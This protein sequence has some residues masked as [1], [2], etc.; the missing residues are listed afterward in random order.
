[1]RQ[2]HAEP[3]A[4]KTDD[5]GFRSWCDA[6]EPA[7]HRLAV[8]L[9]ADEAAAHDLVREVLPR[10]DATW[11]GIGALAADDTA[12]AQLVEACRRR[13]WEGSASATALDDP[14]VSDELSLAAWEAVARLPAQTRAAAVLTRHEGLDD[15]EA[16]RLLRLAPGAVRA[17]DAEAV[18]A[19]AALLAE[20]RRRDATPPTLRA[21]R[22]RPGIPDG[23]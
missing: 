6:R 20:V 11:S 15:A 16:G 4:S 10:M 1:M 22:P 2:R 17:A 18:A 19:V 3:P 7:L 5:D 12:R 14:A 8:L 21:R 23:C 9:T 13:R